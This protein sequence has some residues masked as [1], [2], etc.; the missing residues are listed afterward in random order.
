VKG[1]RGS[2]PSLASIDRIWKRDFPGLGNW[3]TLRTEPDA[4]YIASISSES[5][6]IRGEHMLRTL[7][8]LTRQGERAFAVVANGHVIPQ[9]WNVRAVF[10]MEPAW[11]QP[12]L[13]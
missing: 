12:A 5:R 10:G 11:D 7:V 6:R 9:E 13:P 2:L 4:G 1:L 3:R 8:D